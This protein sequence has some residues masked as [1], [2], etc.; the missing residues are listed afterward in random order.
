MGVQV[1]LDHP[2]RAY[3]VD[4]G[5][6]DDLPAEPGPEVRVVAQL[7]PQHLDGDLTAYR[8]AGFRGTAQVHDPHAADT[9]PGNEPV[10]SDPVR[11]GVPQWHQGH[12]GLPVV[13]GAGRA[14]N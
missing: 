4:A 10:P 3:P 5:E 11:V 9:E 7:R 13:D 14:A 8:G 6:R 2:H 1:C 12:G